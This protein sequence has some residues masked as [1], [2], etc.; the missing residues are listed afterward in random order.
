MIGRLLCPTHLHKHITLTNSVLPF[1][2]TPP[3]KLLLSTTL[4]SSAI[5]R[6][7]NASKASSDDAARLEP[8]VCLAHGA[9]V[10]LTANLWVDVGLVNG[11]VGTVTALLQTRHST[12][13]STC[14]SDY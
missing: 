14:S 11:A 8:K 9:R 7:P 2:C 13:Q 3:L 5:H 12:T 4:Q 6:G 10:M 1:T